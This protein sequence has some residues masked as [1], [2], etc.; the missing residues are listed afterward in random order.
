MLLR[1]QLLA[2]FRRQVIDPAIQPAHSMSPLIRPG[3][4][5]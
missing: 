2:L 5:S 3:Q 4:D 1:D